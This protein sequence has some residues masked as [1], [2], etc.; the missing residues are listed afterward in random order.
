MPYLRTQEQLMEKFNQIIKEAILGVSERAKKLLM[1]HI[2]SDVYGIGKSET[3][4]PSINKSY[5]DGTGTPSYEFRDVA[6]ESE[7]KNEANEAIFSLMYNG[8]L[9][10]KP[11]PSSPLLHGLYSNGSVTDRRAALADI[12]NVS[13]VAGDAD[14]KVDK[15]RSPY[16]DNFI[17]DLRRNLGNW[18]Y[19]EL[20]NRGINIPD[21]KGYKF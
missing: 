21:L 13:G 6:W 1:Q 5:L 19:T 2:N 3:G 10:T 18:L 9:M 16:W 8:D 14:T 4:K 20:N 11:S 7:V 17:E 12:L 15:I